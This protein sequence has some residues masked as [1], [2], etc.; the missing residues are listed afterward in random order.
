[1]WVIAIAA[2]ILAAPFFVSWWVRRSTVRLVL[3]DR[4]WGNLESSA[5]VL[6]EDKNLNPILGDLVEALSHRTG[7]GSLTRAL[8][9][10][11]VFKRSH[12][13]DKVAAAIN[14]LSDGQARQ[15]M[16]FAVYAIFYDS[17]RT[18]I[19]GGILRRVVMYWLENTAKDSKASVSSS[20]VMPIAVAAERAYHLA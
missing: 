17:L 15:F 5:Q 19:S 16:R 20:Q 14:E 10:S 1:M 12:T 7:D 8:L 3:A 2:V 13:E 9:I 6:L 18:S 11:V 4:V